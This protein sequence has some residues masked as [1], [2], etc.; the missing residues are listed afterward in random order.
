MNLTTELAW[1]P[2]AVALGIGLLIGIERE[3]RKGEGPARAAAGLRTFA[4][5]ALLGALTSTFHVGLLVAAFVSVAG[6]VALAYWRSARNDP[7]LTTEVALL[8]TL[9]LGAWAMRDPTMAAAVGVT[10]AVLL[11]ARQRLH[12]WVRGVLTEQ[13][14]HHL[15]LLAAVSLVVWPLM[16]DRAMGPWDAWLPRALWGVVVL[17]L[18]IAGLG[19]VAMRLLGLRWGLPVVGLMGGFVSSTATIAAMGGRARQNAAFLPSAV[20]AAMLSTVG[21]FVQLAA[22]LALTHLPTLLRLAPPLLA[23]GLLALAV[24]A[25]GVWHNRQD[26]PLDADLPNVGSAFS[27]TSALLLMGVLMLVSLLSAAL[28]HGWGSAGLA[29]AAAASGL[30]DTH[31]PAVAVAQLVAA[32]QVAPEDAA[33]P[34]LL[35]LTT[36]TLSKCVA[37]LSAGGQ[38]FAL[39]LVPGLLLILAAAWGVWWWM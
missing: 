2:L 28:S 15:L 7:G 37:A 18:A 29:A 34:I 13:E 26:P 31:A 11:A 20:A 5:V 16:P 22:V 12:H 19:H 1:W 25:W 39:T 4:L 9:L 33:L 32:G 27:L 38:R 30:A 3:R 21:T 23:A 8:I 17:I 10:V 24:G 14:L 35:A 6:Y 36:N